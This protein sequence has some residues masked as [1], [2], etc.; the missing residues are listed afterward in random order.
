MLVI[1]ILVMLYGI[2]TAPEARHS[3]HR[4]NEQGL[5]AR[6]RELKRVYQPILHRQLPFQ[7]VEIRQVLRN[8][9]YVCYFQV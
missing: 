1:N 8:G 3:R 2:S 7:H 9:D 4:M 5:S 6:Y